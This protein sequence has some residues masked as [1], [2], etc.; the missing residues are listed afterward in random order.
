MSNALCVA[1]CP[2]NRHR[3]SEP[4]RAVPRVPPG[5]LPIS[6]ALDAEEARHEIGADQGHRNEAGA[7]R[8]KRM[9]ATSYGPGEGRR[10]EASA[11]RVV[12]ECLTKY[13]Q[14][15][16]RSTRRGGGRKRVPAHTHASARA[17]RCTHARTHVTPIRRT[18]DRFKHAHNRIDDERKG[19]AGPAPVANVCAG[20]FGG[21]GSIRHLLTI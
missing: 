19:P 14:S 21:S 7:L 13:S 10:A 18:Q 20:R 11:C 15:T 2:T 4:H 8:K 16:S 17:H 5:D 3:P 6:S 9:R 12:T 1:V